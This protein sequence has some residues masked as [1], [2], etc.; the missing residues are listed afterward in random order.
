MADRGENGTMISNVPIIIVSFSRPALLE[1]L[2]LSL[3]QQTQPIDFSNVYLFQD[4]GSNLFDDCIQ[5]FEKLMPEGRVI[6][7]DRNLGIALNIDRAER[8]AF[9][10]LGVDVAYFFEDDL[11]LGEN[12]LA[13]LSQLCEFALNE[14]RVGYFAAYGNHRASLDEQKER[15]AEV[16]R[17][18]WKW[19]FGLTKRQWSRQKDIIDPYLDIIR[20]DIYRRRD[21]KAIFAYYETL[22]YSSP[23]T[24]QD[25]AKDV[26]GHVLG[27]VKIMS[28]A[29]FARYE[30]RE[31]EHSRPASYDREGF[32]NTQLYPEVPVL[33]MPSPMVLDSWIALGRRNAKV[34]NPSPES[35]L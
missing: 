13:V 34:N 26:A 27:T 31:G 4:G 15:S 8:F 32:G 21:A 33:S 1:R 20:R 7:A 24:S 29:C 23:G 6:A 18:A 28:F 14:P 30:G 16:V 19:G 2:L 25:G 3:R 5:I 17:M 9:E 22:G 10:V 12:Y 35:K 11:I